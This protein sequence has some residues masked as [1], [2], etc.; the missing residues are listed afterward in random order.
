M[1][2]LSYYRT[3]ERPDIELWLEDVDGNLV[4]L[5]SGYTFVFKLG[6]PGTAATFT[7]STGITGAAGSGVEPSGTPNVTLTFTAN[8]L[9]AVTRGPYTWQLRATTSSLDRIW[10]GRFQMH[11]VIT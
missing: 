10:Q 7:K 11:D 8:E 5:S 1:N 2:E 3:A 9:D 6:E 4:D